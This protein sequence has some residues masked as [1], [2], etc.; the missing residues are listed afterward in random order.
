MKRVFGF[1]KV[2][3]RGI[4][5]NADWLFAAC[6]LVNLFCNVLVNTLITKNFLKTHFYCLTGNFLLHSCE[7]GNTIVSH[8]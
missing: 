2:R 7:F 3:Y 6:A 5:K 1:T 8:M 4:N